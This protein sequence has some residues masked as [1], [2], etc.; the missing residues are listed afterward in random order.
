MVTQCTLGQPVAF[1]WHS[2]VH[3]TSQC[4]L[5]KGKGTQNIPSPPSEELISLLL[6]TDRIMNALK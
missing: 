2:S 3:W 5:A 6:S 4:T 1:Q